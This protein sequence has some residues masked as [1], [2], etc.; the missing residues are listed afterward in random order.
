MVLRIRA[1]RTNC[2]GG[3]HSI[4]AVYT[5]GFADYIRAMN[6]T[7]EKSVVAQF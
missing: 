3:T 6:E 4:P 2:D 5:I 1:I 7:D